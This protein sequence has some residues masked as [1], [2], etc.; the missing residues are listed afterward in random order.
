MTWLGAAVVLLLVVFGAVGYA[1]GFIKE[2]VSMISL[3]LSLCVVWLINP[4]VTSLIKDYTPFYTQ[5]RE[6]CKDGMEAKIDPG[7]EIGREAQK[8]L[9]DE[10]PLPENM[11]EGLAV[12][13]NSE[14]YQLL[15]VDSFT[16]YVADYVATALT[17]GVGFLASFAGTFLA[18]KILIFTLGIVG[19]LPVLRG[20][21]RSAGAVI[22]LAKG[23]VAVWILGLAATV[24]CN[25]SIGSLCMEM[26]EKDF[27]LSF[28][29]EWD[30]FVKVFASIFYGV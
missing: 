6:Y 26:I 5:V 16:D 2:V 14:V 11:K 1:R 23:L 7:I 24:L 4:A 9:I 22:G 17:N 18:L 8:E 3:V 27:V 13:N 12:N 10:L 29:Y 21:N 28:L 20:I 25:T 15:S 19:N 30:L